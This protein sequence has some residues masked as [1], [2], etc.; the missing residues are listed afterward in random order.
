[1]SALCLQQH[2]KKLYQGVNKVAFGE[3]ATPSGAVKRVVTEMISSAGEAVPLKE[4]VLVVDDVTTWLNAFT[5][6]MI[7][8]LA[9][10]LLEC[11]ASG[12][13]WDA[14]LAAF[15]S[16]IHCLAEQISFTTAVEK[17]LTSGGGPAL[18]ALK[19]SVEAQ[20]AAFTAKDFSKE[21]LLNA[22]VKAL[23]LDT[24]HNLDV[25]GIAFVGARSMLR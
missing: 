4:P 1:L 17:A 20:L 16:Q 18:A 10:L 21:P 5:T 13:S 3:Q 23:I 12:A 25:S 19:A 24:V 14:K 9:E 15:P 7:R 11:L 8:T 22:K 2:L 6:E